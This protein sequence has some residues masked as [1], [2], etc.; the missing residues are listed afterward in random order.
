MALLLGIFLGLGRLSS[1]QEV[2]ALK[3]SGISPAQILLPIGT[4]ALFITLITLLM[5]TLVRPAASLTLKKELYNVAKS[6]VGTALREKIF[7]D[8]FP[9]V[10]IYVEELVP[11]GDT[12]QGVLIIDRRNPERENILF[13]KVAIIL[14]D[15]ESKALSLKLFD[16]SL[17]EKKKNRLGFSQ[18]HFN[19]YD[20][21]LD[22][23]EAFSPMRE[24][25]REPKEMSLRRL[26]KAIELK[27]EKGLRPT[28]ELM[29]LHQRFSFS[30]TP[31][32]FSLLGV[33]LSM[34]PTR[35]RA[36]RSWGFLLC[37]SWLLI[38]YGFLSMGKALGEKELMPAALAAWLP[39]MVVG[40]I[41]IHFFRKAMK[42]SPFLIQSKLED[43]SLFMIRKLAYYRQRDD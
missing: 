35:S 43:L 10:L 26:A 28:A 38:Y 29:E 13:G 32:V 7:N 42:E 4:V 40:S 36:S 8:D 33:S 18:T 22:L 17:Y 12:S 5:T 19:T 27:E 30:L 11:P 24:K 37:V 16:G 3:A 20:F 2:L 25:E 15:E 34:I 39:N 14:S 31:L 41:A 6:R 1:D 23:E 9:G 21:K